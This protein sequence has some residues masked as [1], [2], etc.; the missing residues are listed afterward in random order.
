MIDNEI[1]EHGPADGG[2]TEEVAEMSRIV[3]RGNIVPESWWSY[4]LNKK[5]KSNAVPKPNAVAIILLSDVIYWYRA[6][7]VRGEQ[8]GQIEKRVRRFEGPFLRRS[9]EDIQNKFGFTRKQSR[10]ALEI[11][12]DLDLCHRIIR[13]FQ[14][15][16]MVQPQ[17]MFLRPVP[18]KIAYLN[19]LPSLRGG[20]DRRNPEVTTV[21]TSREQRSLPGG[22]DNT[23]TTTKNTTSTTTTSARAEKKE[24]G[25]LKITPTDVDDFDG[26]EA[27]P[28]PRSA[29]P[30][31]PSETA[32]ENRAMF[33]LENLHLQRVQMN[34]KM[35][36]GDV[37]DLLNHY[38]TEVDEGIAFLA[39]CRKAICAT[40]DEVDTPHRAVW[41]LVN[42]SKQWQLRDWRGQLLPRLAS[43]L[44]VTLD[45]DRR[46]AARGVMGKGSG[47]GAGAK[48]AGS[49]AVTDNPSNYDY[50]QNSDQ[51]GF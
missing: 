8:S 42:K 7:E 18:S 6:K 43:F 38:L 2:L 24:V 21:L 9:Y 22:D 47:A 19:G 3:W 10:L 44:E 17:T 35:V 29:A 11:L 28:N 4:I 36:I 20:K 30:L 34:A 45:N 32:A 33:P 50:S 31:S 48:R 14:Q 51:H 40:G 25:T 15:G 46:R 12:E 49:S 16:G 37:S 13:P 1:Y 23:K 5:G 26:V 27:A 41:D 39:A